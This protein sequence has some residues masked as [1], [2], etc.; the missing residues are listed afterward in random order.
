[1]VG[2]MFMLEKKVVIVGRYEEKRVEPTNFVWNWIHRTNLYKLDR[3]Q[4]TLLF[5][6]EQRCLLTQIN[7]KTS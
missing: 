3:V 7:D 6:A 5:R 2:M 4:K 1:M